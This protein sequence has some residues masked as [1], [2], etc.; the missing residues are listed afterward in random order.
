[1]VLVV[2]V[3]CLRLYMLGIFRP[4][5]PAAATATAAAISTAALTSTA[6]T[7]TTATNCAEMQRIDKDHRLVSWGV[8]Q[9]GSVLIRHCVCACANVALCQVGSVLV[10]HCVC[11]CVLVGFYR[12]GSVLVGETLRVGV[13]ER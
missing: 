12:M 8:Y 9:V 7:V 3:V 5:V 6:T 10:R 11:A 1:M 13:R 4:D 2:L